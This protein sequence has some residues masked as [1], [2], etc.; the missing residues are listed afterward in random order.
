M[1]TIETQLRQAARRSGLSIRQLSLQARIPYAAVHGFVAQD[2]GMT[3]TTANKLAALLGLELR[4]TRR[5]AKK[6]G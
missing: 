6:G 2:R 1:T 5:R 3:L 4:P